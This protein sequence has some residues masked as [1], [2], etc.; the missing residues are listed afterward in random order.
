MKHLSTNEKVVLMTLHH[1]TEYWPRIMRVKALGKVAKHGLLIASCVCGLLATDTTNAAGL[2]SGVSA[3]GLFNEANAEQRAGRLGPAILDYERASLLAPR[4]EAIVK[5][6]FTAR[7]KAGVAEPAIATWQRP[8]HWLSFD[9]LAAMTSVCLLL[10]NLLFFGTRLIPTSLRSLA[11][12]VASLLGMT[13][14]LA[15]SAVAVRWPELDRAVVVGSHPVAHIAPAIDAAMS[16]ELKPG[17]LV[18]EEN[19]YGNFVR[20]RSADGRSGWVAASEVE[21]IIPATS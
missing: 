7:Q 10:F 2:P 21:K 6:L 15:A 13:A 9:I 11:R 1:R 8:A 4:D 12:G 14:L 5:N 18:R 17:E 16:F 19:T 3:P 20:V